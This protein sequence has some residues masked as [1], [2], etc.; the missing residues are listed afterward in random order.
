MKGSGR[1]KE[2]ERW[3]GN[4][5]NK[6]RERIWVNI[7]KNY[8][9]NIPSLFMMS[10]SMYMHSKGI[11]LYK[12]YDISYIGEKIYWKNVSVI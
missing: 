8:K 4:Q 6:K 7:K 1:P 11:Y 5:K 2:A 10:R 3:E 9:S 12:V